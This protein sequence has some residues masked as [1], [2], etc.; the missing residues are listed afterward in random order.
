MT[1]RTALLVT[2]PDGGRLDAALRAGPDL[3]VLDVGALGEAALAPVAA[4]VRT[5]MP[6][7]P[8]FARL[9]SLATGG[10]DA[11]EAALGAS[12]DGV[13]LTDTIGRRDGECLAAA[14]AV[15]EAQAGLRDGALRIVASV[16]SPVGALRAASLAEVGP[17]LAAV[18]CDGGAVARE[19][20]APAAG[21]ETVR[22]VRATAVLAAAAAGV[23]A[24]DASA[25]APGAEGAALAR[26]DGF[27]GVL[28][29]DEAGIAAL[30]GPA[31]QAP[32]G[33][34]IENFVSGVATK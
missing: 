6:R 34:W 28:V 3:V 12:P 13:W 23:P 33:R 27:A 30:R 8:I 25:L 7:V 22:A 31:G 4:R 2:A 10:I 26:R 11:V 18:A 1:V 19:A 20:G 9:P 5:A 21:S 32:V 14:L 15:A 16:E 29:R 17:R 24:I